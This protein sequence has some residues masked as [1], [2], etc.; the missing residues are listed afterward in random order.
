[1]H[2]VVPQNTYDTRFHSALN[3]FFGYSLVGQQTMVQDSTTVIEFQT[4]A[5]SASSQ[6]TC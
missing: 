2:L 6:A 3:L 1:M 4:N 5:G